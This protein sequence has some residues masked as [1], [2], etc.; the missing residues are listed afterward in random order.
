LD[1]ESV[2]RQPIAVLA[3]MLDGYFATREPI[4]RLEHLEHEVSQTP[5]WRALLNVL[6]KAQ[7]DVPL[8]TICEQLHATTTNK[9]PDTSAEENPV[10]SLLLYQELVIQELNE[11]QVRELLEYTTDQAG[12]RAYH[13]T[14]LG[15]DLCAKCQIG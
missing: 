12:V 4:E 3:T 10:P 5:E 8:P 9:A 13:L 14:R 11:L 1:D 7:D 6:A 15:H 2:L